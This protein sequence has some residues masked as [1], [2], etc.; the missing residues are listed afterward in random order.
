LVRGS[1]DWY[2][3][4]LA[5]LI[6]QQLLQTFRSY[7]VLLVVVGFWGLG[8]SNEDVEEAG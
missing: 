6:F 2:F 1:V 5:D 7:F 8:G 4:F 3:K